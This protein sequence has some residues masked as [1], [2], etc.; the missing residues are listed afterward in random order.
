MGRGLQERE[1]LKVSFGRFVNKEL[2]EMAMSGELDLG[3]VSKEVTIFFSDIRGFTTISEKLEPEEVVEFLNQYM[4][5]MVKCVQQT[6]GLVDKFIGDAVM[7]LWGAL[8]PHGNDAVNAVNCAILMRKQLMKFNRGRG[9]AR[10][11]IIRIGMGIN[12]G[13]VIA[14]QMGSAEKM[15][16]TVIGDAVN[17]ASRVEHLNKTYGTDILITDHTYEKTG[18]LFKVEEVDRVAVRGKS[19]PVTL[20]AVLGMADDKDTPSNIKELRKMVGIEFNAA[21]AKKG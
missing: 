20:Y 2:A 13:H 11:P 17:T 9:S 6:Y 8:R 12:T 4:T 18:K 21:A 15:D 1:N 10:K 5:E 16:F 3:G 19:K 14:G 7:A